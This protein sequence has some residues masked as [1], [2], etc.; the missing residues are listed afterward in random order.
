M[1][2]HSPH[3]TVAQEGRAQVATSASMA[4]HADASTAL[5]AWSET[6]LLPP[7]RVLGHC[8]CRPPARA[9]PQP[10]PP[11]NAPHA[12]PGTGTGAS[13]GVSPVGE[14]LRRGCWFAAFGH[15]HSSAPPPWPPPHQSGCVP[16]AEQSHLPAM[17]IH[18]VRKTQGPAPGAH[19]S[20]LIKLLGRS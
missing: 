16:R 12:R 7:R 2:A 11:A 17:E 18:E 19:I 3:G 9:Q 13:A 20:K 15:A 1:L 6:P 5:L 4:T 14:H 10:A 8:P